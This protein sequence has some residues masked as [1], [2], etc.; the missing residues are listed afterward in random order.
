VAIALCRQTLAALPASVRRPFYDVATLA[1]GI[2]HLGLGGFHRAHMARL[3]HDLMEACPEAAAWGIVGAGLLPGDR[4]LQAALAA[5][6]R[7]YTLVE[8]D[9]DGETAS[10]IGSLAGLAYG[11]PAALAAIDAPGI[12]IVSLTVTSHGYGLDPATQ[13]LDPGDPLI[14]HDLA[15]P[16]APASAVGVLVE[17]LRRRMAAG[18]PAFTAMSCDNLQGNGEVLKGA[19]LAFAGRIDPALAG[20]IATHGA[21]PS[22]MVDRITPATTVAD[23]AHVAERYGVADQS[24][25]VCERFIQWVIED[26]FADGRPDWDAV[27]AQFVADVAPYERMKLRLL[28]ASHLAV[29]GLG[30]LMGYG[31]VH[32]AIGDGRIRRFMQTL[33]DRETGPTL[34]P[35]PGIE[36]PAYK[37][38]LIR[39]FSNPSIRDTVD[40]VNADAPV[41]YLLDPIR[42]RL[43]AGASV[44]LL[45]LA[46]AAWIRRV[47]G[48]DEAGAPIEVRHPLA[49]ELKARAIAGGPDPRPVLGLAPLFGDLGQDPRLQ[50]ATGHWLRALY[51]RG[52]ARTLELL[53]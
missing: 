47:S 46:L 49:A 16:R 38:A 11:G 50:A 6:D 25:V 42:D 29:A 37:R 41:G 15:E 32:E 22:T 44:E 28:N 30:R 2:V 33:M 21:F 17:G 51:E 7:L 23:I 39:R 40:R 13:A 26:H 48:V 8:R 12:R 24:P 18:R 5:Q 43:A 52:A 53:S 19:V 9:A 36:L 4:A 14:A 35:V 27:S 20:W 3:T 45:A 1:P 31:F 10:V 34:L